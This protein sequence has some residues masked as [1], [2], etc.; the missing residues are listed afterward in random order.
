MVKKGWNSEWLVPIFIVLAVVIVWLILYYLPADAFGAQW[1]SFKN[2]LWT[3]MPWIVV[4][5]VGLYSLKL[6]ISRRT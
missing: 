4:F 1:A 2:S 3:Y 6:L 5:G